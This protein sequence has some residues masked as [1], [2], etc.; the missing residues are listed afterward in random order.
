MCIR[1]SVLLYINGVL[2]GISE[3]HERPDDNFAAQYLGGDNDDYDAMKH[4]Q[5][6]AVN[7]TT[8]NYSEMLSLSRKDMEDQENYEAVADV[9]HVDNFITYMIANYY[10]GNTDWAHQNWY[11]TYNKVSPDGKWYY[12]SWDPEHCMESTGHDST[13]RN[14]SGGPTE[15]FHR[16]I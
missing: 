11:A 3:I 9:L 14:D 5:S 16:L 10:V 7:G 6:T 4:R 13:G 2:W 8:A 12:H 1:D 15:V